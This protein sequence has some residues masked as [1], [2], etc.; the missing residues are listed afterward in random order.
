MDTVQAVSV[1]AVEAINKTLNLC[2]EI[3]ES[4]PGG[5]K[6]D[7][8]TNNYDNEKL[9]TYLAIERDLELLKD[10]VETEKSIFSNSV[11][12]NIIR[13]AEYNLHNL[14]PRSKPIDGFP[15]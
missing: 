10:S 11:L 5:K 2:K 9:N 4:S 1:N 3:F 15:F 13:R 8:I 12:L 14:D 6:G 7:V